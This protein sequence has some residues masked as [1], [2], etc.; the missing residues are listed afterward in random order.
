MEPLRTGEERRY[1][2]VCSVYEHTEQA[3]NLL[4][5][6]LSDRGVEVK[7]YDTS[8]TPASYILSDAFQYSNLVFASTTYNMCIFVT[9]ENLLNDIVHH[10]LKNRHISLIENGSWAPVCGKQMKE[11]LSELPGSAF[12]GDTVTLKS[13]LKQDQRAQLEALADAIAAD[14][15]A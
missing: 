8:V 5:A 7:M 9:M 11:V 14:V 10:N 12:I 1:D 15:K 2:G 13:S 6:F 4:A 3:A